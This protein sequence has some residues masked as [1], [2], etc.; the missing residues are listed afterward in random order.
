MSRCHYCGYWNTNRY[1]CGGCG[2]P[3]R[4]GTESCTHFPDALSP[5]FLLELT[6]ALERVFPPATDE[7]IPV[8]S[9]TSPS[10]D[11]APLAAGDG[12][13]MSGNAR[14]RFLNG[15][16]MA[17]FFFGEVLFV[18]AVAFLFAAVAR[19][20]GVLSV[21]ASIKLYFGV[22]MLFSLLTWCFFPLVLG[23]TPFAIAFGDVRLVKETGGTVRGDISTALF[24]W[25]VSLVYS[26]FPLIFAEYLYLTVARDHYQSLLFQVTGVRAARST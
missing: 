24:L 19:L 1:L 22:F 8:T 6:T 20:L 26:L 15:S 17:R 11:L 4:D 12:V 9:E 23:G 7:F 14:F 3:L 25:L 5:N 16:A 13:V 10:V 21:L 18:V 2:H